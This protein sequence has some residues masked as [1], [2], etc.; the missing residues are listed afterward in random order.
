MQPSKPARPLLPAIAGG[1]AARLV[2]KV[3]Q[4]APQLQLGTA[5][6]LSEH[7][8]SLLARAKLALDY[9]KLKSKYC[10]QG[11]LQVGPT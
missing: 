11:S 6:S 8:A 2:A 5:C 4:V 9:M 3:L 10:Y 7:S 1:C